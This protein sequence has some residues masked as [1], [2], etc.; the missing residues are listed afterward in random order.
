MAGF[1]IVDMIARLNRLDD[2]VFR[3]LLLE[4]LGV[5]ADADTRAVW[6]RLDA[7]W[8]RW[9][10]EAA[11]RGHVDDDPTLALVLAGIMDKV[12]Q[13]FA[14]RFAWLIAAILVTFAISMAGAAFA[15]HGSMAMAIPLGFGLL[16]SVL[17]VSFRFVRVD[18][19]R[20]RNLEVVRRAGLR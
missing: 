1:A 9:V 19:A 18:E 5:P 8:Q 16:S 11:A 4:R 7:E 6:D 20:R 13:Q 17:G 10:R 12:Q 3:A 15:G 2:R 14:R